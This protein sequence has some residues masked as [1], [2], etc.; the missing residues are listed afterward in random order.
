MTLLSLATRSLVLAAALLLARDAAAIP[1]FARKYDAPCGLCHGPAFPALNDFGLRF[2]ERGYQLD[3]D[4]EAA[5]RKEHGRTPNPDERL[6]LLDR[7]PLALRAQGAVAFAPDPGRAGEHAVELRP[8]QSLYLLAGASLFRDVSFIGA[9]TL[10]PAPALHHA[11]LGVHQLFGVDLNL[12][13]GRLLLL[14]FARPEHR[15]LTAYGNPIATSAVGFN[16]TV[17]DST[18][19]GL[20][21]FGRLWGR[22]LFYRIAVVQGAQAPDGIRDLDPHKD[23]FAEL[24][25]RPHHLLTVGLLNHR[26]RTQLTDDARGVRVRFTD[27]FET[28]GAFAELDLAGVNLF[29]QA[30]YVDHDNPFGDGTHADHWGYRGEARAWLAPTFYLVARYDQLTSHHL[31]D[32]AFK[33]ASV[34]LA[35]MALTN[36]RLAAESWVPLHRIEGTTAYLLVDVA[37]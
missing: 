34:H 9:A 3:R 20:D 18:Q 7:A 35:W 36:L 16:P 2:K 30:L 21:V 23:V 1:A 13:F 37:F 31:T 26:G 19:H 12:R 32:L 10:A 28:R 22:R 4:A 8:M 6:E 14:D 29:A 24:H 5:A 27:R 33:Q 17:L 15:F 25:V 11:A